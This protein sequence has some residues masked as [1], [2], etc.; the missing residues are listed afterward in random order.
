MVVF[1]DD[2]IVITIERKTE[3][4]KADMNLALETVSDWMLNN[5]IGKT[6]VVMMT[7]NR[8]YVR[9]DFRLNGTRIDLQALPDT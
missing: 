5:Q 2:V 8:E 7:T 6:E 4:L 3:A 1:A 9:P